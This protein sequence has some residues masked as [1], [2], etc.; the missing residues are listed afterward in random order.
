MKPVYITEMP[1]MQLLERRGMFDIYGAQDGRHLYV[2]TDRFYLRGRPSALPFPGK[3]IWFTQIA[4]YTFSRLHHFLNSIFQPD[5]QA[6]PDELRRFRPLL[7]QRVIMARPAQPIPVRCNVLATVGDTAWEEFKRDGAIAG[8]PVPGDIRKGHALPFPIFAPKILKN[9]EEPRSYSTFV[10][11]KESVG[12][13]V[14]QFLQDKSIETFIFAAKMLEPKNIVLHSASFE[15]GFSGDQIIM[16]SYPLTPDN[17]VLTMRKAAGTDPVESRLDE[18]LVELLLEREPE[19][20]D[21][22]LPLVLPQDVI[23]RMCYTYELYCNIL[24]KDERRR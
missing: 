4:I 2:A 24:T 15:F 18:G 12:P 23:H 9:G 16:T 21:P 8:I 20:P 11:L 22:R 14:A 1:G 3:G 7:H 6:L 17:T 5:K 19:K 13:D 10:E